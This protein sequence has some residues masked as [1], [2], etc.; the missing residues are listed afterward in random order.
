M[1]RLPPLG[2]I[3]AFV[4]VARLG[5]LKA[6][7]ESLSLSS[8]ALTRRIQ[9]LEQF[10]GRPLLERQHNGVVLNGDGESF[11]TEIAPH[12]DALATAVEKASSPN[13]LRLRLAVPSLF[14]SQRL[15]PA[16]PD[17]RE[18]FPNLQID[19]DTGPNRLARLDEGID[20]AIVIAPDIEP[21][22]YSR[23]LK[24][25]RIVVMGS[26]DFKDGDR[27]L[28]HPLDLARSPVLL[29]RDMADSFLA[30][31]DEAGFPELKPLSVSYYDS[32][33]MILDAAAEGMGV[34][35][36]LRSHLD[37]STDRRLMQIFEQTVESPY[38]YWFA[39]TK[40]AISR[41][42]VSAFHDWLF[43]SFSAEQAHQV[44]KDAAGHPG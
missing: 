32:G 29:H 4:H 30:W 20:A 12:I 35:F 24:T 21:K 6:A 1:R 15:V 25:D 26:G 42:A 37:L 8:P 17:L 9:T 2:A 19:M 27:A 10:V 43:D 16:L 13:D 33:Q 34:A 23:L 44:P 40:P 18:R 5:S 38:S 22:L 41:P 11:L 36:M 31:R 39:C 28:N 7:A 3:Q 14:G